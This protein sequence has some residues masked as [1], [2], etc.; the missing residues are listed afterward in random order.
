MATIFKGKLTLWKDNEGFGFIKPENSNS[1][2]EV[3]IHISA[4]PATSRRPQIGDVI[5]YCLNF[6]AKN[7]KWAA[8]NAT[9]EGASPISQAWSLKST[10]LWATVALV[11]L[12]CLVGAI[13]FFI[14]TPI[15]GF[16]PLLA[17]LMVNPVIFLVY[18]LDKYRAARG[19]WRIPESTLHLFELAGGW[20]GG[21]VAQQ[22]WHHKTV[23]VSY[24]IVFWTIVTLHGLFWAYWFVAM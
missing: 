5:N 7:K 1:T 4:L 20:A 11:F 23:K 18:G 12:F 8:T 3:F 24:Q 2:K 15:L 19:L 13:R 14:K 17:Y 22:L 10:W 6:D 9:I 16:I 21:F